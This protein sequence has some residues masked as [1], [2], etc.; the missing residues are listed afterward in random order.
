MIQSSIRCRTGRWRGRARGGTDVSFR[1]AKIGD[2]SI[3]LRR[4]A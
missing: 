2:D 3:Q 1:V 4:I